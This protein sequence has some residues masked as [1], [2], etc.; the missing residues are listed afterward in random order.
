MAAIASEE[1][2][3]LKRLT[4]ITEANLNN[5]QFG[6]S[7]LA[8]K[9]GFSRSHL[10]RRL[11]AQT[12]QSISQ[13]IC[14]VRLKKAMFLLQQKE[15]SAA[16]IA[17]DVGF[18]S[19][20]YFNRCFHEYYGYPPGEVKKRFSLDGPG[21]NEVF[22]KIGIE[23]G[24]PKSNRFT[25][26]NFI[27]NKGYFLTV[28]SLIVIALAWFIYTSIIGNNDKDLSII[29]LPFK[30]LSDN[31]NNQYVADGITEDIL[32][33]LYWITSLRVVSRTSGEQFRES[34]L[35]AR[36]IARKMDVK[37]VLEGSLRMYDEKLRLSV[38]LIDAHSENHLWSSFFDRTMD[39]IY[40][41]QDE[42]ALE[43]ASK[44]NAAL[45]EAEIRQIKKIPTQ[46]S[47]AYNYYLQ[48]RFLLHK[49]NS[50]QRFDFD[51]NGVIN[52]IQYYDKAIAEDSSFTEAYAGLANAWFNLTAWGVLGTNEGFLKAKS[53]CLK[54]LEID[55]DCAEAHAVLGAYLIWGE[56]NFEDGGKELE[57]S[58]QLNPNFATSR[59]WYAQFLMITGP[60]EEAR[61]QVDKALDL[62]PFFWVV[63]NL[64]AWIYYFEEKYDKAIDACFVARDLNP[65]FVSNEWL[66]FLN[67]VKLGKGKEAM[68]MLQTISKRF[69]GEVQYSEEIGDAYDKGGIDGLFTWLIDVNTNR[70]IPVEGMTGHPFFIAWWNAMIG[71]ADESICWLQ[72]NMESQYRLY[73]YFNLIATNPD[74]QFLRDDPRFMKIVDE[75][76]LSPYH[77]RESK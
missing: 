52:C 61:R 45:P 73:H 68:L 47:R 36:D 23:L 51:E 49:A 44:V 41:V 43:V 66:F 69:Q 59:Q 4:E 15:A 10:H 50:E 37:Y 2:A 62:E 32:N 20:A 6:V 65:D 67:Y 17:Y 55:P 29:V 53:L 46:N 7:E 63:Q 48:G 27:R 54:A 33:N 60:I 1:Q 21:E 14:T 13:F 74:F 28:F 34:T 57:T 75:I 77:S 35:S 26:S 40:G 12:G 39:D 22:E 71:D 70:P 76:G 25:R 56:R 58:I 9:M 16:E 11:K 31:P 8:G 19:P 3:F 38:Q 42:I 72:R 5:D 18:S 30:N 24:D 64:N